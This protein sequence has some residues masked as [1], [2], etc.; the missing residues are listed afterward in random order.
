MTENGQ[1]LDILATPL[2]WLAVTL[3]GPTTDYA[4]PSRSPTRSRAAPRRYRARRSTARSAA[5]PSRSPR[6]SRLGDR[7]LRRGHGGVPRTRRRERPHLRGAQ[8]RR[9]R[10]RDRRD[11]PLPRRTVVE[12]DKCN[13]CHTICSPTVEGARAPSTASCATTRTRST[14]RTPLASRSRR[15]SRRRSTSRCSCTSSTAATSSRRAT[16]SAAIRARR[17]PIRPAIRWT[18]ARSLFPGDLRACWACHASTSYLPPLPQ[19]QIP[20]VTGQDL[21]CTDPSPNPTT[22]CT[23]Q[24]PAGPPTTMAP[25]GAACTACHDQPWNVSHAQSMTAPDGSEACVT[26]HGAGK[27]YDVQAVHALPP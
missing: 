23:T 14:I 1:P 16:W 15:R 6:P 21:T 9:L 13:S 24:V 12:R 18:S 25:I 4:Q 11:A 22:Y 17:R 5:T 2:P 20:T 3:A 8:P 7:Q 10:R 26:C 27:V 19:G